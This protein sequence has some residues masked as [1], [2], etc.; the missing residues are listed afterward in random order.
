MIVARDHSRTQEVAAVST[1]ERSLEKLR[2]IVAAGPETEER[3]SHGSP[4]FLE[5]SR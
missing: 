2:K 5:D 3:I 4:T 1:A